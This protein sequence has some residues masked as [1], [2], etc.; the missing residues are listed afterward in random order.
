MAAATRLRHRFW[1][2]AAP[3]GVMDGWTY[4]GVRRVSALID[5]DDGLR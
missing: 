2:P 3:A 1:C 5:P 4:H